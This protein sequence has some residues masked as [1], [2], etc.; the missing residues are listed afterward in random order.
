MKKRSKSTRLPKA[1]SKEGTIFKNV[2]CYVLDNGDRVVTKR[3]LMTALSG[4][5][6]ESHFERRIQRLPNSCAVLAVGTNVEFSMPQGGVAHGLTSTT[7]IGVLNL[8][9]DALTDG[10]LRQDQIPVAYCAVK[11]LRA[12]AGVGL[13]ALID[14]ATGYQELRPKDELQ[15]RLL[16]M[17][18]A[19]QDDVDPVYRPLVVALSRLRNGI[20]Y[21]G[22]GTPPPWAM[23]VAN[24]VVTCVWGEEGRLKLRALN[25]KP[26]WDH[27]DTQHF[28]PEGK[29][30]LVRALGI[31]EA[32]AHSAKS[33]S[34][35]ANQM[36]AYFKGYPLQQWMF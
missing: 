29:Q 35:W 18:R 34:H 3:S 4:G 36:E 19:E 1:I 10:K 20:P 16:G 21:R 5:D 33:W 7:V 31:G 24:I 25:P 15:Q 28:D 8:Y 14:E 11:M 32:Y 13:I 26:T 22:F 23:Q 17:I 9:A 27:R 30:L 12:L 6:E 2:S